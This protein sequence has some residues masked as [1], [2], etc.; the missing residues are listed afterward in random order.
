VWLARIN[1]IFL[2]R[3]FEAPLMTRLSVR[4]RVGFTLI[5]LLVVIAIIAIL[6][7][8]LLPAVQKVREAAARMSCSNNMRQLGI[9][10]HSWH[11]ANG[12]LPPSVLVGPGIGWNDENNIGPNWVVMILPYFEQDNLQKQV[13]GSITN[14]YAWVK[15]SGGGNDQ[16]WR[17]IRATSLK[18]MMCPSEGN[19]ALANANRAGGNWA[20]GN[21]AANEGPGDPG[22]SANAAGGNNYN[23]W[24]SSGGVLTINKS[25]SL[26]QLTTQDGS[27]NTIMIGHIRSG[28]NSGD[29]RGT[30]AFGMPACS[31][32]ANHGVGD[33]YGPNDT[34]CC[35]DDVLGCTDRPDIAMGC[36]SGGYGQGTARSQHTGQVLCTMGDASVRGFRNGI[37]Q[38]QWYILNSR[39]DGTPNPNV[40]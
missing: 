5:E 27:A 36:W 30:W 13:I 20:Q 34:G 24:G 2:F 19:F 38:Y 14:Y 32:M 33:S 31:V 3:S 1:L 17:N 4:R 39:N 37:S 26:S 9:A 6:I 12:T 16:T 15:G 7:G 40:D 22:A 25:V 11:D 8:L 10:C 21:Y 28:P 18:T 23:G 29:M 35:S